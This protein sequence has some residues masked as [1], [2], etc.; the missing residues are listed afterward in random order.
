MSK[1]EKDL[2]LTLEFI[3]W[4]WKRFIDD[5]FFVWTHGE[6]KLAMFCLALNNYHPTIKFTFELSKVGINSQYFEGIECIK[7]LETKCIHFLDLNLHLDNGKL[8]SD[9]YCKPTDCHQ[10]L[11]FKSCHPFHTQKVN[12]L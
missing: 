5:V 9:L 1:H 11:Y 2:L 8:V 12:S 10:Y 7:L 6:E 4:L 3:A